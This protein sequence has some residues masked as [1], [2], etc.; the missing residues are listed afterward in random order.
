MYLPAGMCTFSP[1]NWNHN[2]LSK[3]TKLKTILAHKNGEGGDEHALLR[4]RF[5]T[6]SWTPQHCHSISMTLLF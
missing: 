4:N 5:L 6:A 1:Q 3:I 2:K